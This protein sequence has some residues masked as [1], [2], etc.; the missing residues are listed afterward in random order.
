MSIFDFFKKSNDSKIEK[1]DFDINQPVTNPELKNA[2]DEFY[3][4]KSDEN[5]IKII[6][7]IFK[8]KFL[9]ITIN[10]EIKSS[11]NKDGTTT[12]HE[13]SL[14]KFLLFQND[15]NGAVLPL[16]TD[17]SEVDLSIKERDESYHGMIMPSFEAFNFALSDYDGLVI[18]PGSDGWFL[19]K[20]QIQNFMNDFGEK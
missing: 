17:W 6:N 2:F 12:I 14:I 8:A 9:A 13:G 7:G 15:E 4:N 11:Q 16:F 19:N 10:D 5:F 3:K 20:N 18:N 1:P